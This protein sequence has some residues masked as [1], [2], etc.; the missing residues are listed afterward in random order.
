[1]MILRFEAPAEVQ[2]KTFLGPE[3]PREYLFTWTEQWYDRTTK[4]WVHLFIHAP[5][6][7]PIAWYL[8]AE[9]HQRIH[10]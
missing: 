5:G 2:V 1:M 9:L 10:H 8:D 4:E 6:P 3:D 7:L